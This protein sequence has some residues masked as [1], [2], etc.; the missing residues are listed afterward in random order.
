MIGTAKLFRIIGKS[1]VALAGI[2]GVPLVYALVVDDP[3]LPFVYAAAVTGFTGG[4]L[5]ILTRGSKSDL[6]QRKGILSVTAIWFLISVFGCL[7]FRFS[8]HSA[9]FTA[10]FF[11]AASGFTTTGATVLADVESIPR[12]LQLWRCFSNWIGGMGA[13]LLGIAILPL[14]SIGGIQLYRADFP[15]ARS[16]K[17][18]HR[19]R[20]TVQALWGIYLALTIVAFL[21]LRLS[22]M[23]VFDAVCHSFSIVSTGGFS[24]RNDGIAAFRNPAIE[25]IVIV[26][27]LIAGMN[28][29]LHYRLWIKRQFRR[30]FSDPETR[31]YLLVVLSTTVLVSLSLILRDRFALTDALRHSTF[32]VC[33]IMTGTGL[34]TDNFGNWNSFSQLVLLMLMF[35]GA[36]TGSTSGGLKTAR[37]LLLVKVVG[38]E[39]RRIVEQRGVFIIR[40]GSR[41]IPEQ[42]IQSLLNLMYIAFLT[43]LTSCLLLS[44][45]GMD[46]FTSI[47]AVTACMFNVGPGLGQVGPAF[48]YGALPAFAKW[49]LSIC[50]LVGRLEYY[51][52]LVIC[53]RAF[54]RR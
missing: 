13:I 46:V 28:F 20:E 17:L 4:L 19:I 35:F 10:A 16:E 44:L 24:T 49:I 40:L 22:G 53:T 21:S 52:V 9:G 51:A 32:Q 2:I 14:V 3:F 25:C 12:S 15:G 31:A 37:I 47:S 23:G 39:F 7:P 29:T 36:C 26:L 54:W 18:G 50:M 27:M 43:N 1:L 11:E 45:A 42:T 33:S 48:Q 30:F 5:L 6:A 34:S 41:S 8:Q 38:R